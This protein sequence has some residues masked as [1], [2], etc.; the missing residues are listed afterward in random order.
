VGLA[1]R[2]NTAFEDLSGGQ[3]Q[4]LFVALA[5]IAASRVVILDEMTPGLDPAARRVAWDLVGTVRER[6]TTVIL[7]TYFMDE[8]KRLCDRFAILL[9]GS[10]VA[11]ET[12]PELI[13]S[14]RRSSVA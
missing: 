7:V 11:R 12:A 6:G 5:L 2:R 10:I 4:Q 13:A 9:D 14:Q 1:D 8:A 3:N